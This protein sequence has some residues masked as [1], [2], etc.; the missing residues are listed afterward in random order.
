MVYLL[1]SAFTYFLAPA[2]IR[3]WITERVM[4]KRNQA[5]LWLDEET[6]EALLK[7]QLELGAELG[8]VPAKSEILRASLRIYLGLD[9]DDGGYELKNTPRSKSHRT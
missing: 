1:S 4:P 6:N 3:L 8:R 9:K 7:R 5:C 2:K